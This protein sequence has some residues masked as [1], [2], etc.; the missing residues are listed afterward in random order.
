MAILRAGRMR[1]PRGTS[2]KWRTSERSPGREA[3]PWQLRKAGTSLLGATALPVWHRL[4][5]WR[6][7]ISRDRGRFGL[8][9]AVSWRKRHRCL[10]GQALRRQNS[11][12]PQLC[13]GPD[14]DT[15]PLPLHVTRLPAYCG[16]NHNSRRPNA[17]M[18]SKTAPRCVCRQPKDP[19]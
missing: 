17:R 5:V 14:R 10:N 11:R 13:A 2:D 12:G 18:E 19:K 8:A 9:I 6:H 7:A 16:P 3:G 1:G 15:I 4:P